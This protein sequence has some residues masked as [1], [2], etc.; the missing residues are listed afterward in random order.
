MVTSLKKLGMK[1]TYL[2]I[3]NTIY[4][5]SIANIALKLLPLKSESRQRYLLLLLLIHCST[6]NLKVTNESRHRNQRTEIGE[7]GARLSLFVYNMVLY[8]KES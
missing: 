7:G 8:L 1:G 3:I 4:D 2:N 5:R 6:Q